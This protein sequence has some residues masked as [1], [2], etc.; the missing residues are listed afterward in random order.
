MMI[1]YADDFV[2][3]FQYYEDAQRFYESLVKRLSK[4]NLELSE[5]KTRLISFSRFKTEN[6]NFF[7]FLG[8][9]YRWGRSRAGK[10]L[11]KMR[12]SKKRFHRSLK[13]LTGWIKQN[14]C[15]VG[16]RA[17]LET[18]KQKLQGHYNYYGVCGNITMLSRFYH[19]VRRIVFKWLNRR[20]Q[21]KSYN[22]NSFDNLLKQ[23]NIPIP[24]IIAYWD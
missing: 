1:R 6:S 17:I 20:S 13:S 8:F 16:T 18:L 21:R 22:W 10:P 19:R 9:E 12:T 3:C 11:V 5:M 15:R 23:F 4:F 14:R 24:R 2:C 7:V